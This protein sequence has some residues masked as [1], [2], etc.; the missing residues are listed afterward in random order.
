MLDLLSDVLKRARERGAT[1][2]DAFLV[3]D[4]AFSAQVRLGRVDTV[5][6]AREQH[7]SLRVF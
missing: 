5:K 3:E 6:H 2:A 1:A 4:R 7:L